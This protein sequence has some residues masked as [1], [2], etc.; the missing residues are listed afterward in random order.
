MYERMCEDMAGWVLPEPFPIIVSPHV[1]VW[2]MLYSKV[3]DVKKRVH[4]MVILNKRSKSW[5]NHKASR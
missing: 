2:F 3:E 5:Q 4:F 1:F